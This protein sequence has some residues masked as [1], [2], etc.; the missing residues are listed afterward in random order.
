MDFMETDLSIVRR[1]TNIREAIK[2]FLNTN[3]EII[4]VVDADDNFIGILRKRD[5]VW[6][7]LPTFEDEEM[8]QELISEDY[9]RLYLVDDI[10]EW[11]GDTIQEDESVVKAAALMEKNGVNAIPV[12]RGAKIVGII[13]LT[14][15]LR[16][17][18]ETP[19]SI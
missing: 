3:A 9:Y 8:H 19:E 2:I 16:C 14:E 10:M 4:S 12:L 18:S 17:V 6:S 1:D 7:L 11:D 15:I 13:S 5:I